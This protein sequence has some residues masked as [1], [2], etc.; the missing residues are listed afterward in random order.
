MR[1]LLPLSL[2]ALTACAGAMRSERVWD[3]IRAH[4]DLTYLAQQAIDRRCPYP[5]LSSA[6]L[7]VAFGEPT[8]VDSGASSVQL[9][10]V[11]KRPGPIIEVTLVGDTVAAW[12]AND[13]GIWRTVPAPPGGYDWPRARERPVNAYLEQHPTT[14]DA[15]TYA[16]ARACPQPGMPLQMVSAMWGSPT[17]TDTVDRGD[18]PRTRFVYGFGIEG[19]SIQLEFRRGSLHLGRNCGW[20]AAEPLE[21]HVSIEKFVSARR[22]R[23]P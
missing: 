17:I 10:Y 2:L 19:Q 21:C 22:N 9:T 14:T 8:A 3:H 15:E 18:G 6:S 20:P 16:M 13:R 4:P 23:R 5:G 12:S 1:I 11:L 7:R